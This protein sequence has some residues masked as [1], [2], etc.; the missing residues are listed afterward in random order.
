MMEKTNYMK[1]EVCGIP[2]PAERLEALPTTE[3]CVRCSTVEAVVGITVWDKTTPTL[4]TVN[5]EEADLY[6]RMELSEGRL[7]RF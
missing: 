4:V 3:T 5:K 1:C 7:S 2:I 6:R